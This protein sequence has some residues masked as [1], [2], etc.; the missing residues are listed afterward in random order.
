MFTTDEVLLAGTGSG[1]GAEI[2]AWLGIVPVA[3]TVA[4]M[5]IGG[6]LV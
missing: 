1:S 5:T 6:M 3:F 4:L 2:V